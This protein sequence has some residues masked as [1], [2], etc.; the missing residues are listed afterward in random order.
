MPEPTK[1]DIKAPDNAFISITTHKRY[2][3][4]FG[5]GFD[6]K[7]DSKKTA[8]LANSNPCSYD[9]GD[10]QNALYGKIYPNKF[11]FYQLNMT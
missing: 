1:F 4:A 3:L 9:F 6:I 5:E 2:I 8:G 10:N 11:N 7:L